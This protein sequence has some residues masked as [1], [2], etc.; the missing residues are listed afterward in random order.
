[1]PGTLVSSR[2][3]G[4]GVGAGE[5]E[6]LGVAGDRLAEPVGAG[7]GAE[8]EEEEGEGQLLAVGE[9]HCLELAVVAMQGADF[10]AVADGDAV[11]VELLDQV[12][13]HRLAEVG[14]A[15]Q[16]GD[17]RAAAGE[18]D[19]RLRGRVAAADHAHPLAAAELRL[20]RAGGVEDADPLVVVEVVDRQAAVFGAG[21]EQHRRGRGSRCLPRAGPGGARRRARAPGRGRASPCGRRTCAPG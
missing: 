3:V 20:G 14:A 9:R 6:A 11:A 16:E 13:R 12:V 2:P 15:V 1:M 8:E 18:P 21:R 19:R 10:A 4:A 5:D 7:V 17:Q